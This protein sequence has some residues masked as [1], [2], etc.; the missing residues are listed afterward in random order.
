MTAAQFRECEVDVDG[1]I[2][3]EVA[4]AAAARESELEARIMAS[5]SYRSVRLWQRR[6]WCFLDDPSTSRPVRRPASPGSARPGAHGL[7]PAHLVATPA[8]RR[9][10][11]SRSSSWW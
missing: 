2:P 6:L 4:A 9:P 8:P 11:S 7:I 5:G 10:N 1:T 3:A